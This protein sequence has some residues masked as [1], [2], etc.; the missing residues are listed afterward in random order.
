MKTSQRLGLSSA[1]V[2]SLTRACEN[3]QTQSGGFTSWPTLLS[4]PRFLKKFQWGV[5]MQC[6][7]N[8]FLKN[9][10]IHRLT[11]EQ[12]TRQNYIDNFLLRAL[13]LHL[14]GNESLEEHT[15]DLFNLYVQSKEGVDPLTFQGVCVDDFLSI[16]DLIKVNI[17]LYDIHIVDGF[18][19]GELG[20]R[21]V[22]KHCDNV[23]LT[24]YIN[25]I[26]YVSKINVLFK[27]Y[28]CSSCD[29]FFK[30]KL[31]TW[32]DTWLF[33]MKVS[34]KFILKTFI[35]RKEHSLT[36]RILLIFHTQRNEACSRTWQSLI[37]NPFVWNM[38]KWELPW[39]LDGLESTYQCR[40]WY[41]PTL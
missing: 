13:A 3:E 11:F 38:S 5:K 7:P 39:Q 20:W 37:L 33:A 31:E 4:L 35:N 18:L 15:S 19:I 10:K 12:N 30:K 32:S 25:S 24:R 16:E 22:Q 29:Q 36:N 27:A 9:R 14:Y 21:S 26:C 34:T 28:C 40:S 41:R 23:R 2:T 1:T 6:Y 17:F 8:L